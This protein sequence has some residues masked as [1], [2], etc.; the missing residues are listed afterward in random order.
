MSERNCEHIH[1]TVDLVTYWLTQVATAVFRFYNVS[2]PTSVATVWLGAD[3][4]PETS[5]VGGSSSTRS[6][7]GGESNPTLRQ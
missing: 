6:T 5:P 1:W 3:F 7:R 4:D 2:G